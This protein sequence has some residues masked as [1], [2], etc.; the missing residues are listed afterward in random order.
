MEWIYG[1]QA[2]KLACAPG[3]RRRAH[4]LAGTPAALAA[5]ST[6][7]SSV[8]CERLTLSAAELDRLTGS[9]EHQGVALQVGDYPY[10]SVEELLRGSL[11]VVLDEVS[12]PRNLGAVARS[13]LAAGADGLVVPKRR[14]ARV[15]PAAVKAAAGATE[16]LAIARVTNVVACLRDLQAA[17]F[18]VYGGAGQAERSYLDLQLTGKVALVFGAEGQGLRRLVAETCDE[19][20]A[21]PLRWPMES[22]NVSV[23]AAV[24]LFEAARQRAITKS[25][26]RRTVVDGATTMQD[27]HRPEE[28]SVR[29]EEVPPA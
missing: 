9:S 8:R 19:L 27:A 1:R 10:V 23:A 29:R 24:F 3:A 5:L 13:A 28:A 25:G 22:L 17:G 16:H 26:A 15:T 21:I 2:V 4:K 20:G 18:W 7:L 6:A 14:A 12:D 11:V